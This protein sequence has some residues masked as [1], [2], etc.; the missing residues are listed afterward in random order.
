MSDKEGRRE[1]A[2]MIAGGTIAKLAAN[3]SAKLAGLIFYILLLR[4]LPPEDAGNYLIA[5][6]F[7]GVAATFSALGLNVAPYRFVQHYLAVGRAGEVRPFIS[8]LLKASLVIGLVVSGLVYF[9]SGSIAQHYGKPIGGLLQIV[10]VCSFFSILFTFFSAVLDSLKRLYDSA[11][12]YAFQYLSKL[13][14]FFI[15]AYFLSMRDAATA[16][17]T[18][19]ACLFASALLSGGLLFRAMAALPSAT[20]REKPG[21]LWEATKFGFPV[22]ISA[23]IEAVA[24]WIDAIIIGFFWQSSLVAAYSSVMV[25]GRNVVPFV[26]T[27]INGV[28]QTVLS[29]NHEKNQNRFREIVSFGERWTVYLGLPVLAAFVAFPSQIVSS[30]FPSYTSSAHLF[31][32]VS[33]AFF[34]VLL[35]NSSRNALFASGRSDLLLRVALVL[36]GLNVALNIALVPSMGTDGAAYAMLVSIVA[37][38]LLAIHYANSQSGSGQ[39]FRSLVAQVWKGLLAATVS[40]IACALALQGFAWEGLLQLGMS[41]FSLC[42]IYGCLMLALGAVGRSEGELMLEIAE[43]IPYAGRL[44]APA[45]PLALRLLHNEARAPSGKDK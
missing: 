6:A 28:Q 44:V 3:G 14:L 23:S 1:I 30:L 2:K 32:I 29:E 8:L 35:S 10:A 9:L 5:T 16:M 22:Y 26:V 4:M 25:F 36:L 21:M 39:T 43:G 37:G 27:A 12:A 33:P 20:G 45:K 18:F 38:E 15:A 34:L 31:Y 41:I 19:A 13:A 40:T 17:L 42:V 24:A 11:F 7:L